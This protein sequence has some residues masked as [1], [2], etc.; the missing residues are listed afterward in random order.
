MNFFKKNTLIFSFVLLGLCSTTNSAVFNTYAED[1][2]LFRS[3]LNGELAS[4]II[5][6]FDK[7]IK[8][9]DAGL[10]LLEK[11]RLLQVNHQYQESADAYKQAF[12]IIDKQNNRAKVSVSRLGFKALSLLSNDSVMP[13]D[14]PRYEQVLAHVA[15]AKNYIYLNNPEAAGVEMRIAQRIQREIEIDHQ[16]ELEKKAEKLKEKESNANTSSAFNVLDEAFVGLDPI[17]G[18]IKNSYQN[19]YAFYMAANLWE[20]TGEL[21]DALV[22]YKKSYELQPD[23]YI[24][25]DVKRLDHSQIKKGNFVPVIVFIEQGTVPEKIENKLALPLPNGI[26]NIAF[27]T[28]EPST[29]QIP[30]TLRVKVGDKTMHQSFVLNDIGALAV[31]ELKEK[32]LNTVT[33]QIIRA[34]A[35]YA[36]QQ[37]LGNQLGA[38]GQLAGTL[39]NIATERA[40]LRAWSTLPSNTQISR[41]E[42]KP[43]V[44]SLQI[45]GR[46]AKSEIMKLEALP[47][48]TVFVYVNDVNDKIT[49]SVSTVSH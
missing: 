21:N 32:T 14:V 22:D 48:Q 15:Q 31:K 49:T 5:E 26:V 27:A 13:Y 23:Q 2:S 40:D 17:A 8:S 47:N 25:K 4:N 42:L 29:Y 45:L 7:K 37:E 11:A 44:H 34:T 20:A 10:Y 38:I 6:S 1:G 16:K 30:Q 39:M 36:V 46:K 12:E 3:H 35:K 9:K 18:K 43:G 28:Y 33:T 24:A 41:F 19:A